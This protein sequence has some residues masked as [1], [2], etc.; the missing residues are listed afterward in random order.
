MPKRQAEKLNVEN[1]RCCA[2]T[3]AGRRLKK[4]YRHDESG[5]YGA[6]SEGR[7]RNKVKAGF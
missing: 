7:W 3:A 6:G 1:R 5:Q 4:L 2:R